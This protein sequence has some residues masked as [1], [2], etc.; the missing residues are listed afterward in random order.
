MAT[1]LKLVTPLLTKIKEKVSFLRVERIF[2]IISPFVENVEVVR[3]TDNTKAN[4]T[5][6][7]TRSKREIKDKL[8]R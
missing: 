1:L 6:I 3:S 2:P 7:R 8:Y 4:V 5:F